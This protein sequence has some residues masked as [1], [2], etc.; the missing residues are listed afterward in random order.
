MKHWFKITALMFVS[1]LSLAACTTPATVDDG[2]PEAEARALS[3]DLPADKCVAREV[4]ADGTVVER[5]CLEGEALCVATGQE[6]L[7]VCASRAAQ[8]ARCQA[9]CGGV[10]CVRSESNICVPPY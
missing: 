6:F 8:T 1:A 2:D 4:Q 10:A 5:C 3:V 9:A 7:Y